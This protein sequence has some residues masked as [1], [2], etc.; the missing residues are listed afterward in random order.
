MEIRIAN[1]DDYLKLRELWQDVF[2][3][4]A[5][6]IDN[7]YVSL[8]A[9]GYVLVEEESVRSCLTVFDVGTYEGKLVSEIYAVCTDAE[10]RGKGFASKL[11]EHARDRIVDD[12]KVAMICPADKELIRF[13]EKLRFEPF[14]YV[15][16]KAN[17]ENNPH[18]EL[19]ERFSLFVEQEGEIES[20]D[21]FVG[22]EVIVEGMINSDADI[23]WSKDSY[24]YFGFPMK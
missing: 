18:I 13:Y 5:A 14:F 6:Y 22:S 15:S 8:D 11:V 2:G 16:E 3:D 24:P 1:S 4:D 21:S 9:T 17:D 23:R 20:A 10:S 7:L 19:N 12:G